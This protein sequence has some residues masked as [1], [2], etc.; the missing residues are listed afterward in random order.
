M[1]LDSLTHVSLE[2][3]T[4]F[5]KM[6][7]HENSVIM[8]KIVLTLTISIIAIT[9]LAQSMDGIISQPT[10]VIGKRINA[11]GETTRTF[12]ADFTYYDDGKAKKFEFPDFHV[13][14]G[15]AFDGDYVVSN[16]TSH[17]S[18]YPYYMDCLRYTYEEGKIVHIVHSWDQMNAPENW[19]YT[20]DEF[21]RLKQKDY[22]QGYEVSYH[23][24]YKYEYDDNGHTVTE[25]YWTSWSGMKLHKKTV[26]HYDDSFVLET[27]LVE[28]YR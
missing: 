23:D 9:G 10:H 2:I 16:C 17:A 18:G 1:G 24:H 26:W 12:V 20:Y 21:G 14:S 6:I 7:N 13:I 19:Q 3:K 4:Y 27:L 15:Y 22:S 28:N 8:K 25:S 11:S 5:C